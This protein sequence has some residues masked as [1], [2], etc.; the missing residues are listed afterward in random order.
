MS[1]HRFKFG[2]LQSFN[3]VFVFVFGYIFLNTIIYP[4]DYFIKYNQLIV[5]IGASL[6]LGIMLIVNNYLGKLTPK[7]LTWISGLS[8]ISLFAAQ[9]FCA[10]Y[11]KV[12]PT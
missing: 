4:V 12:N 3:F 9:L 6:V 11:F 8:F 10:Y 5:I 2:L 7:Y 1:Y